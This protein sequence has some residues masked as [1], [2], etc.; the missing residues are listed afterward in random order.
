VA[1]NNSSNKESKQSID[2]ANYVGTLKVSSGEH[3]RPLV[4]RLLLVLEHI[5]NNGITIYTKSP[6]VLNTFHAARSADRSTTSRN[7]ES[8]I[9]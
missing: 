9:V 4:I 8:S 1:C 5:S 2:N 7:K 3:E 6:I